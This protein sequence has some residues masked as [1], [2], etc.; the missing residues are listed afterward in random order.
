MTEK[1]VKILS[2]L[3]PPAKNHDRIS[4]YGAHE[5]IYLL[6]FDHVFSGTPIIHD[7]ECFRKLANETFDVHFYIGSKGDIK[8]AVFF[9]PNSQD[10]Y[11]QNYSNHFIQIILPSNFPQI[12]ISTGNRGRVNLL[13][14]QREKYL[15]FVKYVY[16]IFAENSDIPF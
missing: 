16:G 7:I 6:L 2:E 1:L 15:E 12:T 9:E 8:N 3:Y 11:Q 5:R 4:I 13:D 10:D 14:K